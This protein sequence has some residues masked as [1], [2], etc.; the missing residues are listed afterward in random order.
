MR[1]FC[2]T[3]CCSCMTHSKATNNGNVKSI[4]L[5][6]DALLAF[7]FLQSKRMKPAKALRDGGEKNLIEKAVKYGLSLKLKKLPF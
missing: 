5:S 4:R 2:I 1:T 7:N 6:K 3:F